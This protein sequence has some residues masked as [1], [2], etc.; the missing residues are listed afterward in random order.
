[1]TDSSQRRPILCRVSVC[2]VILGHVE[3]LDTITT[4]PHTRF[5]SKTLL[6]SSNDTLFAGNEAACIRLFSQVRVHTYGQWRLSATH[7]Q[8]LSGTRP[9][10]SHFTDFAERS[11]QLWSL[12]VLD[13]TSPEEPNL[14]KNAQLWAWRLAFSPSL[15]L[16]FLSR[17]V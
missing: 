13:G 7:Y 2:W 10:S 4:T 16:M 12:Y 14:Q 17:P 5:S 8:R 9:G 3:F 6:I 11:T 1:M 15:S